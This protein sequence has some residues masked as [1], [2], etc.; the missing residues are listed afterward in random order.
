M[1]PKSNGHA[2]VGQTPVAGSAAESTRKPGRPSGLKLDYDE[3]T[4][5]ESSTSHDKRPG[6]S[7]GTGSAITTAQN[8]NDSNAANP[9]IPRTGRACLACRKLKVSNLVLYGHDQPTC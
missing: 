9:D 5:N 7:S 3:D 1:P 6:T 8:G 4:G 2:V